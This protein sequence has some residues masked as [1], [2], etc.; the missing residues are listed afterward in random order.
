M[1]EVLRAETVPTR[2]AAVVLTTHKAR[3]PLTLC[4]HRESG[5]QN[6]HFS[7]HRPEDVISFYRLA[8]ESGV[9]EGA[10]V[11]EFACPFSEG[12]I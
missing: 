9:G 10:G 3:L 11:E 1:A 7:N 6:K 2:A 12:G 8:G 4:F 5:G